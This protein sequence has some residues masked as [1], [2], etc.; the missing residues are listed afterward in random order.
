M[1]KNQYG[2]S[3]IELMVVVAIIGILLSVALPS[4]SSY[5][6]RGR[7]ADAR[8]QLM[9]AAQFMQRFYSAND[10]YDVN[11]NGDSVSSQMASSVQRAPAEGDQL[12]ALTVA[13]STGNFTLTMAPVSGAAMASDGCGSFTIN[14]TGVK[15]VTGTLARDTCWR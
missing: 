8:S 14:S 12:Y 6:A 3:M 2:F 9:L 5:V 7:R 1:K 4:Y 13:A 15:G 10:R 11:R